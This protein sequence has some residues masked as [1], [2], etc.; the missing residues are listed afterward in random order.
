MWLIFP[1]GRA[2][3]TTPGEGVRV[4]APAGMAVIPRTR[5]AP[6]ARALR[7]VSPPERGERWDSRWFVRSTAARVQGATVSA[8]APRFSPRGR[9]RPGRVPCPG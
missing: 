1:G 7:A 4:E 5:V 8:V 2:A 3:R 6:A 9:M